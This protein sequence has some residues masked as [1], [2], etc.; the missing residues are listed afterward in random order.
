MKHLQGKVERKQDL[1]KH[2]ACELKFRGPESKDPE[3]IATAVILKC[4]PKLGGLTANAGITSLNIR[5]AEPAINKKVRE[6]EGSWIF[7]GTCNTI[8]ST[9]PRRETQENIA[10]LAT[11]Q[12]RPNHD[13]CDAWVNVAIVP[14]VTPKPLSISHAVT[15]P[16]FCQSLAQQIP[17]TD[18][19]RGENQRIP[20][21]LCQT[22]SR[23]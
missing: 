21:A 7:A 18:C 10:E 23:P 14:I 12:L 9:F 2:F 1:A 16:D 19:E 11:N 13:R 15:P 3:Q 17:M 22:E 8:R 6:I 5:Q 20:C 4:G